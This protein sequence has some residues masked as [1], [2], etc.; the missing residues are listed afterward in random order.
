MT[1]KVSPKINLQ[2]IRLSE[3]EKKKRREKILTELLKNV[4]K[5]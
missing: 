1:I 5:N 3:E 4:S 2:L